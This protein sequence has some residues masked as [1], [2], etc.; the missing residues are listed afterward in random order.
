MTL[1]V[2]GQ[3]SYVETFIRAGELEHN[4]CRKNPDYNKKKEYPFK[5]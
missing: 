5:F 3:L 4:L 1:K 2:E